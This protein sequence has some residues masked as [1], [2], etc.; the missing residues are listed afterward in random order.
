MCDVKINSKQIDPVHLLVRLSE[1]RSE[2]SVFENMTDKGV[3][4]ME[5]NGRIHL[6]Q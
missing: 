5:N 2:L 1:D 3:I 4:K 6:S